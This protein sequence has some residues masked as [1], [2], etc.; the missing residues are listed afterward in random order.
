MF[1][2]GRH[3][4]AV[5]STVASQQ[6]YEST[7]GALL[8]GVCMFSLCL[9]GFSPGFLPQSKDMQV[10][11]TGDSKLPVGVNVSGSLSLYVGNVTD[12]RP[13][14]GVPCL[15]LNDSSDQLQHPLKD[16][17]YRKWMDVEQVY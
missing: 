3:G 11:L 17:R 2:R 13:V 6:G 10:R 14:Q 7:T 15:S 9:R 4:G 12:W 5:S 8:R 1:S 16:K